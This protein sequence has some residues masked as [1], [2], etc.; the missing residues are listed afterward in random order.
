MV[1]FCALPWFVLLSTHVLLSYCLWV[2]PV[3]L[4]CS[5]T[6]RGCGCLTARCSTCRGCSRVSRASTRRS[7]VASWV[8]VALSTFR[9][10]LDG[11]ACVDCRGRVECIH[12]VNCVDYVGRVDCTNRV[13]RVCRSYT[14]EYINRVG[15][16]NIINRIYCGYRVGCVGR[17]YSRYIVQVVLIVYIGCVDRQYRVY[18]VCR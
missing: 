3:P 14:Y 6:R 13:Y 5:T 8:S 9:A 1:A 4:V 11:V 7:C 16:A 15:C 17:I 12:G 2:C 18:R 10:S